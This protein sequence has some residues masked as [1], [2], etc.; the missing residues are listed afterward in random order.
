[1][2]R[3]GGRSGRRGRAVGAAVREEGNPRTH[4]AFFQ[5]RSQSVA[6]MH[7]FF[8]KQRRAACV[9]HT[10]FSGQGDIALYVIPFFLDGDPQRL[11]LPF[12]LNFV[13]L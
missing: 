4:V 3:G 8:S 1:M 10:F 6:R 2:G 5:T 9:R 7:T 13:I 12:F 11:F